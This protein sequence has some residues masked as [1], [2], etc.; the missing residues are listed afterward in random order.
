[1]PIMLD[2]QPMAVHSGQYAA[3]DLRGNP[4]AEQGADQHEDR[5]ALHN[6]E[7]NGIA[8][9]MGSCRGNRGRNDR[10]E[11]SADGDV[12]ANCGVHAK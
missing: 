10:G 2:K 8:P 6:L 5:P 11:R 4:R 9:V 3:V 7:I 1:M 12:H